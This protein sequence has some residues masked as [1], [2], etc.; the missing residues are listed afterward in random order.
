[1]RTMMP[2]HFLNKLVTSILHYFHHLVVPSKIK[3]VFHYFNLTTAS[4]G[5]FYGQTSEIEKRSKKNMRGF[6]F[7]LLFML[8]IK[9]CT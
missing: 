2:N 5:A 4:A 9:S 6:G 7:S 8:S 3:Y 1:M